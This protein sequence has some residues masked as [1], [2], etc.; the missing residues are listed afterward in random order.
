MIY[1]TFHDWMVDNLREGSEILEFGSGEGTKILTSVFNVTSIEHDI[2]WV[3]IDPKSNYIHAPFVDGWYD[4]S[5]L[6]GL[7]RHF[8]AI[9]IDGPNGHLGRHGL[10]DNLELFDFNTLIVMD[11]INRKPEMNIFKELIKNREYSIFMGIDRFF[12]VIK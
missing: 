8:D 5:K 12:G 7:N 10:L 9:L 3:G 11:D 1:G 2:E 4:V 6:Q